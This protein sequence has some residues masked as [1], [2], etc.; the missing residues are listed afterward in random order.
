MPSRFLTGL[1]AA[2]RMGTQ[3]PP[4]LQK[5]LMEQQ[6]W[7]RLGQAGTPLSERPHLEVR[8]YQ[9]II[10]MLQR[11]ENARASRSSK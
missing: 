4:V 10:S 1:S 7:T 8:D 11:D 9:L 6:M 3:G 5:F 2:I